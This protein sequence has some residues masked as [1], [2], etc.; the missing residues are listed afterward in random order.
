MA[1][2][3]G[4]CG[5]PIS[6]GELGLEQLQPG[7]GVS[8]R[9]SR[10][11]SHSGRPVRMGY[12]RL[13]LISGRPVLRLEHGWMPRA[14]AFEKQA[15]SRPSCSSWLHNRQTH[16]HHHAHKCRSNCISSLSLCRAAVDYAAQLL[17]T[18][19]ALTCKPERF[20][21]AACP[22]HVA[23]LLRTRDA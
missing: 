2:D 11:H 12:S 16:W 7:R 15:M 20:D 18:F 8:R 22:L 21:K 23:T 9:P 5:R 3:D 4:S 14:I 10:S 6:V 1:R 17:L 13:D 19:K